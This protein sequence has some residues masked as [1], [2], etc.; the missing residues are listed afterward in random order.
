MNIRWVAGATRSLSVPWDDF[1]TE[2][3]DI[4]NDAQPL[5]ECVGVLIEYSRQNGLEWSGGISA[6]YDRLNEALSL[7]IDAIENSD[8]IAYS[9]AIALETAPALEALYGVLSEISIS[10]VNT[11]KEDSI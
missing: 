8:C 2:A 11:G 1:K 7:T 3:I 4:L 6:S 5:L 9:D 10:N